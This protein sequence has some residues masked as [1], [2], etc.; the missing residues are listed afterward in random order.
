[1]TPIPIHLPTIV[2]TYTVTPEGADMSH[3]TAA[4]PPFSSH[5]LHSDSSPHRELWQV[6]GV[7]VVPAFGGMTS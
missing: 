5:I 3:Y 7:L 6:A 4:V 2:K 1:M